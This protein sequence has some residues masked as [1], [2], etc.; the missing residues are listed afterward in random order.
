VRISSWIGRRSGTLPSCWFNGIARSLSLTSC[1]HNSQVRLGPWTVHSVCACVGAGSF[2][3]PRIS[4]DR[5]QFTNA[6]TC[7]IY[8]H[9]ATLS[10][11]NPLPSVIFSSTRWPPPSIRLRSAPF[12]SSPLIRRSH[13][14]PPIRARPWY[15]ARDYRQLTYTWLKHVIKE[16]TRKQARV[17]LSQAPGGPKRRS[18]FV[19]REFSREPPASFQAGGRSIARSIGRSTSISISFPLWYYYDVI[20]DNFAVS[21]LSAEQKDAAAFEFACRWYITIARIIATSDNRVGS[22][23]VDLCVHVHMLHIWKNIWI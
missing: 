8:R 14:H 22:S 23:R 11:R 13:F 15:V 16:S 12:H 5:L 3:L 10:L 21:R 17:A 19:V 9:S 2:I 18:V 20:I 1:I 6:E 4:I 7:W